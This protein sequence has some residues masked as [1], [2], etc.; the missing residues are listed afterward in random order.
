MGGSVSFEHDH[1]QHEYDQWRVFIFLS[2]FGN[3]F[4]QIYIE[5]FIFI[6]INNRGED[7]CLTMSISEVDNQ[8]TLRL[9]LS[10]L[11]IIQGM[12]QELVTPITTEEEKSKLQKT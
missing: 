2:W 7:L 9:A 1:D 12:L 8:S 4:C 10:L 5:L 6:G 3:H 11:L